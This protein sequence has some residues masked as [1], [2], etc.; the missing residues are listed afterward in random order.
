MKEKML[1]FVN[2][3]IRQLTTFGQRRLIQRTLSAGSGAVLPSTLDNTTTDLYPP[4]SGT[5]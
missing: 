3:H 2:A 1:I 5:E 4:P